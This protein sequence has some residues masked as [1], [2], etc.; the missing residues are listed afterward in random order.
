MNASVSIDEIYQGLAQRLHLEWILGREVAHRGLSET[1]DAAG[2]TLIGHLNPVRR[3]ALSVIGQSELN[4]VNRLDTL[5]LAGLIRTLSEAGAAAIIVANGQP[6]P[7]ALTEALRPHGLG[8]LT[9]TAPS[10]EVIREIRYFIDSRSGPVVVLHGVLLE[11]FGIGV[12]LT[13]EPGVGKS[14]LALELISRGHRLIA[15]DAPEFR[16]VAP[17]TLSGTCPEP[18]RNFMEVRGLGVLNIRALYGDSAVKHQQTLRLVVR[19]EPMDE[20]RL[21]AIDRLN[22]SKSTECVLGILVP[23]I[24]LPVAPGRDLAVL[25][26]TAVRNQIL[27]FKGYDASAHFSRVQMTFM[28]QIKP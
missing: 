26:E 6:S 23:K 4:Y 14:E 20:L 3:H 19:L 2:E 22:G 21:R 16:R 9:S 7:P 1:N 12:L 27:V 8:L 11:V 24:T 28:N 25:L 17:D 5:E 10:H 13:G 18:L 15:D